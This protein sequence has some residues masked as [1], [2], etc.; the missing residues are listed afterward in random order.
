MLLKGELKSLIGKKTDDAALY[1]LDSFVF[2]IDPRRTTLRFL[3]DMFSDF[4]HD[5]DDP[6]YDEWGYF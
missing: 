2:K 5:L 1:E 6:N 4:D 3:R